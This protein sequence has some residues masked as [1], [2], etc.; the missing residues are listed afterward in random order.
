MK[1]RLKN[2]SF[3]SYFK[4][5]FENSNLDWKTI[6]LLPHMLTVDSTNHVFQYKLL[7]KMILSCISELVF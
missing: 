7:N 4:K 1:Y 5:I 6:Y 3:K 2:R